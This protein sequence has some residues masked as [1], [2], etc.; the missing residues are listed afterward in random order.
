MYFHTMRRFEKIR[1]LSLLVVASLGCGK[2]N[3]LDV[4]S[5]LDAYD[6]AEE[7]APDAYAFPDGFLWGVAISAFQTEGGTECDY[8]KWIQGG[9]AP[10]IGLAC[11]SFHRFREDIALAAG[12]GAKM[13]RLGV[14]WARVEKAPGVFDDDA[15]AHYREVVEEVRAAGMKPLVT[16]HHFTNPAWWWDVGG[17]DDPSCVE[18]FRA[19]VE[20][21]AEALKDIVDEWNPMNEP[22]IYVMGLTL[23][24]EFPNGSLLS[25]TRM[26]RVMRNM[27]FAHAA[28]ANALR[29]K[30]TVDADKDGVAAR[31]WAVTATIPAWPAVEGNPTDEEGAKRYGYVNNHV[32][33]R[34]LVYGELDLDFDGNI[35]GVVDGMEEGTYEDLKGT[36]DINGINYYSRQFIVGADIPEGGIPCFRPYFECGSP[37][38]VAGDNLN[39]VYP[40]GLMV[41]LREYASYGLPMAITENGV[42]D[43]DDDLRPAFIVAHLRKVLEAIQQGYDIRAYL[44]WSLLDNYEW[45]SGFSMHFGLYAVDRKTYE[46]TPREASVS[47]LRDIFRANALDPDLDSRYPMPAVHPKQ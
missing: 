19:Y 41:V 32:F 10:E 5:D 45:T 20:R 24:D 37:G 27:V 17:W 33:L 34:A 29:Q 40:D 3:G 14:E 6:A 35:G 7:V 46:R 31:V 9:H 23:A 26:R 21:V 2:G 8:T 47:L 42:A 1:L 11:D 43:N 4:A 18:R 15:L 22:M 28:A 25:P 12:L 39:E 36:V 13:F 38:P 16:L 30:D 44:H